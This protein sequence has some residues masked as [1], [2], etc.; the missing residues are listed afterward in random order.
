MSCKKIDVWS[1]ELAD[2]RVVEYH[3]FTLF[4][5]AGKTKCWAGAK[6]SGV[7]L[8]PI[9]NITTGLSRSDVEALFEKPLMDSAANSS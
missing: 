3:Y 6:V 1:K 7:A 8:E 9:Q 2:G 4:Q 5:A